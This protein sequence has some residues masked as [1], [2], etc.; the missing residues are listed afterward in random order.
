MN[1][2]WRGVFRQPVTHFN[3]PFV[4]LGGDEEPPG[5]PLQAGG[6]RRDSRLG[7]SGKTVPWSSRKAEVLQAAW[8]R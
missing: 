3:R 6:S 1:V 7:R 8:L 5:S 4:G 2:D